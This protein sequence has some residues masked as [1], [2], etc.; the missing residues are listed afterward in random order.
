M[1]LAAG[2]LDTN[3]PEAFDADEAKGLTV[4]VGPWRCASL[5]G[6]WHCL[7]DGYLFPQFKGYDTRQEAV[8]FMVKTFFVSRGADPG[9]TWAGTDGYDSDGAPKQ[10]TS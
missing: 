8:D 1:K 3:F 10:P 6:R 5:N 9:R 2:R 4:R 7:E